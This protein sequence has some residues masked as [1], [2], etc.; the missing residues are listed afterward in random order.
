MVSAPPGR[1][2]TT[3]CWPS[4]WLSTAPISRAALSVALPAAW[5][6]TRRIGWSGYSAKAG[7]SVVAAS[8]AASRR[9]RMGFPRGVLL[10]F[11]MGAHPNEIVMAGLDPAISLRNAMP[12]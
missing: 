8:A 10:V 2:S 4:S 7:V 11:S 5:G 6:T 1:F 12:P 9:E 3:T